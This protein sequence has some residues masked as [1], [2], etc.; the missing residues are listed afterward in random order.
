M[1]KTASVAAT[2]PAANLR[3]S[4]PVGYVSQSGATMSDANFVQ[5]EIA[6]STPRATGLETSQKPVLTTSAYFFLSHGC[7]NGDSIWK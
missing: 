7:M 4:R 5:P 2:N 6:P 3:F 1:E